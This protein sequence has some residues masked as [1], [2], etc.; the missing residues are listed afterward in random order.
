MARAWKYIFIRVLQFARLRWCLKF[1]SNTAIKKRCSF[2]GRGVNGPS[3]LF[4]AAW[5]LLF[6]RQPLGS[7][8]AALPLRRG[9]MQSVL[10][11]DAACSPVSSSTFSRP[12]LEPE[13]TC[14]SW[15]VETTSSLHFS[16]PGVRCAVHPTPFVAASQGSGCALTWEFPKPLRFGTV[17]CCPKQLKRTGRAVTGCGMSPGVSKPRGQEVW[18]P[19][20]GWLQKDLWNAIPSCSRCQP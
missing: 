16:F 6:P 18:W 2:L 4:R 9:W 5:A 8:S 10:S 11:W 15:N 3:Q 19:D 13:G 20:L 17:F 14:G 7:P 12:P 1:S